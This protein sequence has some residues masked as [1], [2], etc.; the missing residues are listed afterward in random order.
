MWSEPPDSDS[1]DD[2]V[3]VL[4][5]RVLVRNMRLADSQSGNRLVIAKDNVIEVV[6]RTKIA[7]K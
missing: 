1:N 7:F 2:A 3:R 4:P 6:D 5:A